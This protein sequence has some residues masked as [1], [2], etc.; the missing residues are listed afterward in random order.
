MPALPLALA[1]LLAFVSALVLQPDIGQTALIVLVWGGLFFLAGYSLIWIGLAA[2][3]G[4]GGFVAA[5]FTIS[6]VKSRVDRFLYPSSGDTHQT[7]MALSALREGGWFGRGPGEGIV[8]PNL[9]D[10]N[11]D[12][13]FAATGGEFGL[14]FCLFL[15]CLYG[16]IVWRGFQGGGTHTG[17]LHQTCAVRANDALWFSNAD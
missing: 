14:I 5:Y 17:P 3:A 16:F 1:A 15:V 9:P 2:A 13:I 4:A 12:Y 10:A 7:D 6:H 11:T 8:K